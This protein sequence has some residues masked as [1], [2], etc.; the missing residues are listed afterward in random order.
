MTIDMPTGGITT[1]AMLKADR[2]VPAAM[3]HRVTEGSHRQMKVL[4]S[5]QAFEDHRQHVHLVKQIHAGT[6]LP[7][8]LA[9]FQGLFGLR[10]HGHAFL[11]GPSRGS[12]QA[13]KEIMQLAEDYAAACNEVFS[14]VGE[15]LEQCSMHESAMV[16]VTGSE[17]TE[18]SS[19]GTEL[20]L[21]TR[22]ASK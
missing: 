2:K 22:R 21:Q 7:A 18:I 20:Q 10:A 5:S 8:S 17:S 12:H 15:A 13:C 19:E 16:R 4:L 3:S 11:G 14:L 1:R 6:N 9:G